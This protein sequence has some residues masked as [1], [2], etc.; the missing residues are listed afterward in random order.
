MG[1]D[2]D[3]AFTESSKGAV[4][5]WQGIPFAANV[6]AA[7][8]SMAKITGTAGAAP[9]PIIATSNVTINN[10]GKPL[11]HEVVK[12]ASHEGQVKAIEKAVIMKGGRSAKSQVGRAAR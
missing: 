5:P 6:P 10:T 12:K 4:I 9:A 2:K 8:L 11:D 1:N 3:R 7:S